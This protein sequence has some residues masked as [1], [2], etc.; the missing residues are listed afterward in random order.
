MLV[1]SFWLVAW[2]TAMSWCWLLPNHYA[3]WSAF[4]M[5][6]WAAAM[7]LP[8]AAAVLWRTRAEGSLSLPGLMVLGMSATPWVQFAFGLIP[9]AGTAWV[10]FAYLLGFSLAIFVGQRWENHSPEQ[11]GDGLFLAIGMAAFVSVGLQLHQWQQLDLIDIWSMGNGLGRPYANFGQPNQLGTLLLWGVLGLV[12]AA[13]RLYVRP[14]VAV[15]GIAFLLFGLA[16]T[17]S[18][19]AWVGLLALTVSAWFWRSLWPWRRAAWIATSLAGCFI[20]FAWS[21]PFLTQVLFLGTA[22]TDV[23]ALTRLTSETRPQIWAMLIEAVGQK[24]WFGYG[25][26]QVSIAHLAVSAEH[27]PLG[28]LFSHAHNLFLD[29]LVW[30]GVPLGLILI[31]LIIFWV[32]CRFRAVHDS[33]TALMFLQIVIVG[34]H[35]MLELPLHYAYFLLPVGLVV[36]AIDIRAQARMAAI[37]RCWVTGVLWLGSTALLVLLVRDYARVEA[38][39]QALRFELAN[40]Q[41][42][43]PRQPPDVLLLDQL[44]GV[45]ALAR[46]E[47]TAGMSPQE[48]EWMYNIASLYPTAGAV[49]KLAAALAW[50][51]RPNDAVE[52]LRRMC[53]VVPE[54]QCNFIK[55]AW[56]NQ[57]KTD[58]LI[59]KARWLK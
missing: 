10:S 23:Q 54:G 42:Q 35:A 37:G 5:D 24:P 16:L 20:C 51:N 25:W 58:P 14:S 28:V 45:I 22:D 13:W 34:N 44:S 6:A 21:I 27:P 38:S 46:F 31:G 57:S 53:A 56:E 30:N 4:H 7:C 49:H 52:W 59:G 48:L 17:A 2:A 47:P 12:W 8:L 50:K 39:Y 29:L 26:N 1:S 33:G 43:A 18:R 9:L 32:W 19:T 3:P 55:S 41:T 36:G 40:I 11:V 15:L